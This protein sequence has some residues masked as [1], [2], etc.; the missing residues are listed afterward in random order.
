MPPPGFAFSPAR[1]KSTGLKSQ[2]EVLR[3][4]HRKKWGSTGDCGGIGLSLDE[5][6]EY[7]MDDPME[8]LWP[9]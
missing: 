9:Y 5:A 7:V 6:L 4:E 3:G 2:V 1:I 8:F